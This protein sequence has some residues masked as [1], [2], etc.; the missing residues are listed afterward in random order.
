MDSENLQTMEEALINVPEKLRNWISGVWKSIVAANKKINPKYQQ[1][2][3]KA[4]QKTK[5]AVKEF[6][7]KNVSKQIIKPENLEHIYKS[8]SKNPQKELADG[9]IP[10]TAEIAALI[11]DVLANPDTIRKSVPTN[12]SGYE[13]VILSKEYADGTV[14]V[15]EAIPKNNVLEIYTAYVWSKEKAE[16][17]RLAYG[18]AV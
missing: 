4:S 18:S 11:P 6:Y 10:I 9:Q 8:H 2:L 1:D 7:G 5:D 13:S 3:G 12:K 16:K 14:H 15:V 17:K